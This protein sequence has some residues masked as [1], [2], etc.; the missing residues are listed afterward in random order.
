MMKNGGV[1][2][3]C[4]KS[5]SGWWGEMDGRVTPFPRTLQTL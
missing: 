3:V 1:E 4:E 2:M 5:M